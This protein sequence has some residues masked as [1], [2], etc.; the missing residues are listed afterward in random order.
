M[1]SILCGGAILRHVT[2]MFCSPNRSAHGLHGRKTVRIHAKINEHGTV[3][4]NSTDPHEKDPDSTSFRADPRGMVKP[5]TPKNWC[6]GI[7][8]FRGIPRNPH[9]SARIRAEYQGESKDLKL[10]H[11]FFLCCTS[12]LSTAAYNHNTSLV[13]GSI[14]LLCLNP[15]TVKFLL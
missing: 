14:I 12:L 15:G 7:S 10:C 9:H 1:G 4:V 3:L 2:K 11:F 8:R 6:P 13:S 5:N